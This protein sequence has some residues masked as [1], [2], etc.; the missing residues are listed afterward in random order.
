[1]QF[2]SINVQKFRCLSEFQDLQTQVSA[3]GLVPEQFYLFS[4]SRSSQV[5]QQ[6][7]NG[8]GERIKDF[9]RHT[10]KRWEEKPVGII[11][12]FFSVF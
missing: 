2:C 5:A 1:M 12:L 9:L 6:E 4:V 10:H 7:K 11:L 8:E 3:H